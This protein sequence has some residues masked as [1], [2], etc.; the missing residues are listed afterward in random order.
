MK[1]QLPQSEKVKFV[2]DVQL[3]Y[4]SVLSTVKRIVEDF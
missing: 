4:W 1:F 3:D 2:V